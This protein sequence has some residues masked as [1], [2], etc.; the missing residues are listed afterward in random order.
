MTYLAA[1]VNKDLAIMSGVHEYFE[2][3]FSEWNIEDFLNKCEIERFDIKIDC[4][5]KSLEIIVDYE[6]GKRKEKATLL[7]NRYRKASQYL[8]SEV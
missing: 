8:M 5:L 6:S 7:L 2:R 3:T 4:Y 1:S